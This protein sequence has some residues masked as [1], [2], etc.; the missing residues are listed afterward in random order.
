MPTLKRFL[1][2]FWL[3]GLKQ[4]WA[5]LFAGVLLFFILLTRYWYPFESLYRYDFLFIVAVLTQLLL[6]AFRLESPREAIVIVVFHL[7]A[8]GME[9]F[10]TAPGINSW[11]YPEE[12]V[13]KIGNVPLFAGFMYSAV[14]SYLARVWRI[15]EFRYSNYPSMMLTGLMAILIYAN[16]FTHHYIVDVRWWLLAGSVVLFGRVW[17]YYRVASQYRSMPLVLGFSLVAVF[18]W[19]AENLATYANVWLYPSQHNG[20]TMVSWEKIIAWY[21]LMLISFVLV[22]L[23]QRPRA[24]LE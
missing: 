4:A 21:L 13:I 7:V 9:L 5:C 6:L 11:H 15:F 10:K 18:I 23:V 1:Y 19:F 2:E 14:G 24:Y 12:A 20:W 17:I 22:S 16:F 3:F 8:T